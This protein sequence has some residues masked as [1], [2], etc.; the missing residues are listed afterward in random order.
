MP[1][2]Q[3]KLTAFVTSAQPQRTCPRNR[4]SQRRLDDLKKVV[5]IKGGAHNFD[6]SELGTAKDIL[7]DRETTTAELL[8]CLRRLSCLQI[9]RKMLLEHDIGPTLRCNLPRLAPFR[10]EQKLG[11]SAQL[12]TSALQGFE[13]PRRCRS[14]ESCCHA[15][16]KVETHCS[17]GA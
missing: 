17:Q 12:C 4:H 13:E 1:V 10:I 9:T 5:Y 6:T 8:L 15:C 16:G 3:R 7:Q 14:G 11:F 2:R